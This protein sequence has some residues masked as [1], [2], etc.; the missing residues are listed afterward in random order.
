MF[1]SASNESF[2]V[3][4]DI[5]ENFQVWD[6]LSDAGIANRFSKYSKPNK[7]QSVS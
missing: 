7:S 5:C 2:A 1:S 3:M 6:I 4:I